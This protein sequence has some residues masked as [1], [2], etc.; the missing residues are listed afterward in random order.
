MVTDLARLAPLPLRCGAG[1]TICLPMMS[2]SGAACGGC[3]LPLKKRARGPR[4]YGYNHR[5]FS[6]TAKSSCDNKCNYFDL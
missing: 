1:R 4:R 2:G 5:K 3:G 6:I